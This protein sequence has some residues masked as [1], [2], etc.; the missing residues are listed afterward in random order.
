MYVGTTLYKQSMNFNIWAHS[1]LQ[2][3]YKTPPFNPKK[4][5]AAADAILAELHTSQQDITV[6]TA[7]IIYLHLCSE[8]VFKVFC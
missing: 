2:Y 3:A 8:L 4:F 7:K 6:S 5:K 1:Y